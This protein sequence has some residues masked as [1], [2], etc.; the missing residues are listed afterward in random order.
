M[1]VGRA[2]EFYVYDNDMQVTKVGQ[3]M[4]RVFFGRAYM[5]LERTMTRKGRQLDPP[6]V[7]RYVGKAAGDLVLLRFRQAGTGRYGV[8]VLRVEVGTGRL[9]GRATYFDSDHGSFEVGE[10]YLKP[11]A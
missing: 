11:V 4:L 6:A 3:A 7:F 5:R 1:N 2:Q 10:M 8:C 9:V